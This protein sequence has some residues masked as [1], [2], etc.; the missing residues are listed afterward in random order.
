MNNK[1][2][3][4]LITLIAILII[5]GGGWIVAT[6]PSE[7]PAEEYNYPSNKYRLNDYSPMVLWNHHVN[8]ENKPNILIKLEASALQSG[9]VLSFER[10]ESYEIDGNFN[11][12]DFVY[13]FVS[14]QDDL[15][16]FILARWYNC[17][18]DD[19]LYSERCQN[20]PIPLPSS[21]SNREG[22]SDFCYVWTSNWETRN[23]PCV[24][25]SPDKII[26]NSDGVLANMIKNTNPDSWLTWEGD[27]RADVNDFWTWSEW[28][29]Q[30]NPGWSIIHDKLAIVDHVDNNPNIR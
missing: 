28:K 18:M 14:A 4:L 20:L 1:T 22:K 5:A 16:S 17:L 12:G 3:T 27:T 9:E 26:D 21:V 25:I 29:I 23:D 2:T 6:M 10:G 30:I 8:R 24:L 15:E 13:K 11:D 19:E 7:Q